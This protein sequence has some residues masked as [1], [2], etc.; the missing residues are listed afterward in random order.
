[1]LAIAVYSSILGSNP[2]PEVT[3]SDEACRFIKECCQLSYKDTEPSPVGWDSY[4]P[5]FLRNQ[6][7]KEDYDV[8]SMESDLQKIGGH[9]SFEAF[10]SAECAVTYVRDTVLV[11]AIEQ[12]VI[13]L[14]NSGRGYIAMSPS[15]ITYD[16][17]PVLSRAERSPNLEYKSEEG[18]LVSLMYSPVFKASCVA[19]AA[20]AI[21]YCA[22][23]F[24][25][26]DKTK[27]QQYSSFKWSLG[28]A[29]VLGAGAYWYLR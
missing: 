23:S 13:F 5:P 20:G 14:D 25:N 6:D 24:Y 17:Q 26:K 29:A 3:V 8:R 16:T 21:T 28:A 10:D 11:P 15:L 1:M 2:Y 4:R 22:L 19:T 27:E 9:F 12:R 7:I 18:P